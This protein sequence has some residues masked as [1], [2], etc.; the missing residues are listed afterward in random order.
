MLMNLIKNEFLLE[1]KSSNNLF[2]MTF[3]SLSCLMLS[4][5]SFPPS[6]L[7]EI[8]IREKNKESIL[9]EL[10]KQLEK[11]ESD[12]NSKLEIKKNINGYDFSFN[13]KNDLTNLGN[14]QEASINLNKVF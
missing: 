10:K 3:F 13:S 14:D 2:Y 6:E 11:N 12:Y 7:N 5:F 9:N 8:I 1:M 4:V